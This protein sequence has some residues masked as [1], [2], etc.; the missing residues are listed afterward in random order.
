MDVRRC[1]KCE[2]E[3]PRSEFRPI[4]GGP[5]RPSL[6][7][8][9]CGGTQRR[10][11]KAIGAADRGRAIR[12]GSWSKVCFREVTVTEE[13]SD[14][15]P[16]ARNGVGAGSPLVALAIAV[17]DR[18]MSDLY[19]RP[20]RHQNGPTVEDRETAIAFFEGAD[21]RMS[22][23]DCLAIINALGTVKLD[24]EAVREQARAL[25]STHVRSRAAKARIHVRGAA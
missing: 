6:L 20:G 1:T 9:A 18:S 10:R 5:G 2:K 15:D 8:R 4:G 12:V 17:I 25:Y 22:F 23:S 3:R 21:C 16:E 19:Y 11:A 24:A 13:R 7:C 14:V